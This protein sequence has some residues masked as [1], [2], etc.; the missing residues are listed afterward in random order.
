MNYLRIIF[1]LTFIALKAHAQNVIYLQQI[2]TSATDNITQTGTSNRIGSST[3][4]STINGDGGTFTISQIGSSNA[5][6]FNLTGGS[7]SFSLT[8]TGDSNTQGI[9]LNGNNNSF[10][11]TFTGSSN[12]MLFNKDASTAGTTQA[13]TSNGTFAF[14]VT[15]NSNSFLIGESDGSYNNLNYTVTVMEI[16]LL[17]HNRVRLLGQLDIHKQLQHLVTTIH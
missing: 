1:V 10:S 14:N 3:T 7:Y 13:T 5:L 11:G 8:N 17:L 4:P 9:Y 6:D 2:S 12:T 15:G 16:V